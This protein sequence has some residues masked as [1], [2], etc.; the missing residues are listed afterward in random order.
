[1]SCPGCH[2]EVPVNHSL[3]FLLQVTEKN[4]AM[5]PKQETIDQLLVR[6]DGLMQ[7][8]ESFRRDV[9]ELRREIRKL[10]TNAA[11]EAPAGVIP[12][13]QAPVTEPPAK[14][15]QQRMTPVQKPPAGD[16]R[17]SREVAGSTPKLRLNLEKFIGEHLIS[18]IG[19]I[20]IVIGAGI[21]VKYAIDHE[22]ISPWTRIILG[23]LLGAG[24]LGF[25]FY[26]RKKY[27][28]FSA[29]LLSGSMAIFYFI[30]FAA[31]SFY[32]L[33]PMEL[34]FALMVLFT[35]Y[36]VV[37]SIRYDR[38]VIAHIGLV[39]AYAVPFLLDDGSGSATV[40]FTYVAIINTGILAIAFRKYWKPISYS[41]FL[42][43]WLI[44]LT[45]FLPT[46]NPGTDF[47][48]AALFLPIYFFTFYLEFLAYKLIKREKFGLEDILLLL[49]NAFLFYGIGYSVL[50][51]VTGGMAYRGLFTAGN[52]LIHALAGFIILSRKEADRNLLDFATGLALAFFT[53]A[54]PVQLDGNWVSLLWSV[55]AAVLFAIGR[56]RNAPVYELLS[57]PL[58]II[59]FFSILLDWPGY[60]QAF[61]P[62]REMPL[63]VPF[64]NIVFLTSLVF[65][66]AFTFINILNAKKKDLPS[67]EWRQLLG[68]VMNIVIPAILLIVLFGTFFMEIATFWS[69]QYAGSLVTIDQGLTVPRHF[70]DEDI[71]QY[72]TISL[73][74][75]SLLFF[76]GLSIVNNAKL[77]NGLLG[78]VSLAFQ[79]ITAGLFLTLG[80]IALGALRD[81]YIS[82]VYA[83][84]YYRGSFTIGIR[85]V[86]FVALALSVLAMYFCVRRDFQEIDFR[87]EFDIF[88]HLVI[89]T[90]AGNELINWMDLLGSQASYKLGLSILCGVYSLL[91]IVLGIRKKKLHLR[92]A[93]IVLFAAT[94]LKLFLYDL[95]SLSTISKT[96]VFIVLGIL[97][98]IIAFLYNKYKK[99]IF[100]E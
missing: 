34:T 69:Q 2:D 5:N 55:E 77:K 58:M 25:A 66:A 63:Y 96:I 18:K 41:S 46:F 8:Q 39:G 89:L 56:L 50:T 73:L 36:A 26:L 61:G 81:S 43:T 65:I 29:V 19:I 22:L 79:V 98:L 93:A 83:E 70:F 35:V 45:W 32:G 84:Y 72:K 97:L 33:L 9:E 78:L 24:L 68:R 60:Y 10:E 85:Y 100:E 92:I 1:L 16:N 42:L 71:R 75:Y 67:A 27:E 49:M 82:Q 59:A 53:V 12:G 48:V 30:T 31:F 44:F 47:T 62:V 6:L 20:I 52:A 7:R 23:Y 90:V 54:I 95:S 57:Y 91:M 3:S 15:M 11:I 21:G 74:V 94:L 64:L 88:I 4:K 40:L 17:P 80:L 86:S 76:T 38:Q 99:V 51:Q 13:S 87:K 14:V 37:E 28:N